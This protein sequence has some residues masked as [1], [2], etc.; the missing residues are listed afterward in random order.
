V[1]FQV[2]DQRRLHSAQPYGS[3]APRSP[4]RTPSTG[5]RSLCRR[6]C[7]GIRL[8]RASACV[9]AV[10]TSKAKMSRKIHH[11]SGIILYERARAI[12]HTLIARHLCS[13][14]STCS[15]RGNSNRWV[16][17]SRRQGTSRR[18][19]RG[20]M[21]ELPSAGSSRLRRP[22]PPVDG[23]GPGA[24]PTACLAPSHRREW[25]R[26]ESGRRGFRP[27]SAERDDNG[28]QAGECLRGRARGPQ[29]PG[30]GAVS[31]RHSPAQ[32]RHGGEGASSVARC[33]RQGGAR[34]R[35]RL[36]PGLALAV[37]LHLCGCVL[38][39]RAGDA[40]FFDGG[41]EPFNSTDPPSPGFVYLTPRKT[42]RG[43]P[44][45]VGCVH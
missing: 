10:P 25:R 27:G 28:A 22:R 9:C 6:S 44:P 14:V 41:Q 23:E 7:V 30:A 39:D 13:F 42:N 11:Q 36:A 1:H 16:E 5:F 34:R 8:A 43:L 37:L 40:L 3:S 18:R 32:E 4:S 24:A 45:W 33:A 12:C 21:H 2:D 35:G 26:L 38:G 17:F 15:V 31:I 29:L 20:L 19:G